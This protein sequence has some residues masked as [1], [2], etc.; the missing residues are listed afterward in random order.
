MDVH[1]SH[2]SIRK[3]FQGKSKLSPKPSKKERK[4]DS[5]FWIFKKKRPNGLEQG[6]SSSQPDLISAVA[7][8]DGS[9]GGDSDGSPCGT[10]EQSAGRAAAA[11]LF[12]A[13]IQTLKRTVSCKPTVAHLV[14]KATQQTCEQTEDAVNDTDEE[15]TENSVV[16]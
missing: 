5:G 11:A 3:S 13:E 7:A 10:P 8:P 15:Q 6:L 12:G 4:H 16:R 1:A 2:R 14:H 9:H